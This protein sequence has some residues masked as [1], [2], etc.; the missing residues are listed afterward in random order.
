MTVVSERIA[1]R[2]HN[3]T[4]GVM[5]IIAESIRNNKSSELEKRR[6]LKA[7]YSDLT[8]S[9]IDPLIRANRNKPTRFGQPSQWPKA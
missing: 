9:K 4:S 6:A 5:D 7:L 8:R 3:V 1:M 2:S